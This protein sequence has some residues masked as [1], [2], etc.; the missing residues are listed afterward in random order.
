PGSTERWQMSWELKED[1]ENRYPYRIRRT[2]DLIEL[3]ESLQ[4]ASSYQTSQNAESLLRRLRNTLPLLEG[5]LASAR[6]AQLFEER[7]LEESELIK[8]IEASGERRD[9]YGPALA[10]L[11][12]LKHHDRSQKEF[13]RS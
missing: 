13:E 7:Q 5:E 3:L 2:R 1:L 10:A 11:N 12:H 9:R 8:W 6:R 4:S